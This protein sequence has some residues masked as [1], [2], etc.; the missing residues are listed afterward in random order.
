MTAQEIG[1]LRQATQLD[2]LRSPSGI[3]CDESEWRPISRRSLDGE[4]SD[5]SWRSVQGSEVGA[6]MVIL[7]QPVDD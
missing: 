1:D 3:R 4:V 7:V 6:S 5:M 2:R